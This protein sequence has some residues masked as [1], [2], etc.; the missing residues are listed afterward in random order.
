MALELRVIFPQDILGKPFDVGE[1][2]QMN[3]LIYQNLL[4]LEGFQNR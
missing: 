3:R 2:L 1:G 4:V